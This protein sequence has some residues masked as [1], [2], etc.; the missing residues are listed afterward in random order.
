MKK[1][2]VLFVCMGNIC[3]SPI[4][5]GVFRAFA[6]RAGLLSSIDVDSAGTHAGH[7]GELPDQRARKVAA[8]RGYN[9]STLRARRVKEQDFSRFDLIVAMDR[10]NLDYLRRYCPDEYLSKLHLFLEF[11]GDL[12]SDEVPDPYYG[13]TEGFEKVLDLCEIAARGLIAAISSPGF[14]LQTGA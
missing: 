6:E 7:E 12:V 11:A 1:I 14:E 4:A 10:Q 9:L 3:R 2:S 5:E 13:G 8:S